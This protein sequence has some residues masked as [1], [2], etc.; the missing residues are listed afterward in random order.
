MA[1][2]IGGACS[3]SH[4]SALMGGFLGGALGAS[5]SGQS[6]AKQSLKLAKMAAPASMRSNL[7][8]LKGATR[9]QRSQNLSGIQNQ[10]RGGRDDQ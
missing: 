10:L 8:Q 3:T 9:S 5:S 4:G 6:L 2:S 1:K 7:Q